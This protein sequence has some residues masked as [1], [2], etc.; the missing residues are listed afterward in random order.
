V[1]FDG[2]MKKPKMTMEVNTKSWSIGTKQISLEAKTT[3][4]KLERDNRIIKILSDVYPV[5]YTAEVVKVY[6][7]KT[8][9]YTQGLEF[10]GDQWSMY[11][12]SNDQ[13]TAE[14]RIEKIVKPKPRQS[15]GVI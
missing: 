15:S 4:G 14:Q 10:D 13:F 7:H 9:S 12:Y 1:L 8:T 3:E 5:N 2:L 6:P 11:R